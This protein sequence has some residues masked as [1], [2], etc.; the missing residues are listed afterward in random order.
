LQ[1]VSS[2]PG[3]LEPVFATMLEKAVSICDAKYGNIY[4]WDGEFLHSLPHTTRHRLSPNFADVQRF[5]PCSSVAWWRPRRP[6]TLSMLQQT[7]STLS[8]ALRVLWR[9]SNSGVYDRF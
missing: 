3:D 6:S 8:D 2:S 5:D 7:R 9:L 4:R 1:V